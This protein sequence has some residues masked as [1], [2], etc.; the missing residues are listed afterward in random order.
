MCLYMYCITAVIDIIMSGMQQ[1]EFMCFNQ[2][3][4]LFS[5]WLSS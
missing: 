3:D 5:L 2:D 1:I 4:D